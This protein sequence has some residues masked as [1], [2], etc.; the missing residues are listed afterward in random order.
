MNMAATELPTKG[1]HYIRQTLRNQMGKWS[2]IR[3]NAVPK[4]DI[5]RFQKLEGL[6][7]RNSDDLS[8]SHVKAMAWM[9]RHGTTRINFACWRISLTTTNLPGIF[10][11]KRQDIHVQK[12]KIF[13]LIQKIT[14]K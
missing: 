13:F 11:E 2:P 12:V 1:M 9:E 14:R 4:A 3:A 10:Y 8:L 6:K 5:D 7:R